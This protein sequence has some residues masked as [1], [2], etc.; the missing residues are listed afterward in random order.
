MI[1]LKAL[2]STAS[3][4]GG[5]RIGHNSESKPLTNLPNEARLQVEVRCTKQA[6]L[7]VRESW[8]GPE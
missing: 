5:S 1:D 7:L 3:I 8:R 6:K 4:E 2:R